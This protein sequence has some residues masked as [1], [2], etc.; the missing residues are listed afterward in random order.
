VIFILTGAVGSGKTAILKALTSSLRGVAIAFDGFLSLRVMENESGVGYDLL[1]LKSGQSEPFLRVNGKPE[2]QRVGSYSVLPQGLALAERIINR[3]RAADL[4]IVDEIGPLELA[5]KGLWPALR[6]AM[7]NVQR[8]F[9]LVVREGLVDDVRGL[10]PGH[11]IEI[12]ECGENALP[13][14]M[15]A[16]RKP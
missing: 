6:E 3:S 4:L 8:R 12:M 13:A 1:D 5:G 7:K 14:L 2:G 15:A 16:I 9:C 11:E 10:F